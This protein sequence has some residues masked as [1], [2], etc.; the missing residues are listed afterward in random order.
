MASKPC[1]K[2]LAAISMAGGIDSAQMY[3]P[4]FAVYIT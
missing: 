2:R 3:Q 1:S 4:G